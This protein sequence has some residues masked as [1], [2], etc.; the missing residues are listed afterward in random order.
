[1]QGTL[2]PVR[3]SFYVI[4]NLPFKLDFKDDQISVVSSNLKHS[5]FKI[6]AYTSLHWGVRRKA[7][8]NAGRRQ[9][10]LKSQ[11][12]EKWGVYA[13]ALNNVLPAKCVLKFWCFLSGSS[14][15][16]YRPC[17]SVLLGEVQLGEVQH[18][19]AH[20]CKKLHTF[21]TVRFGAECTGWCSLP[22]NSSTSFP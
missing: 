4:Y 9:A 6:L 11:R 20:Y 13:W 17:S 5:E 16:L 18:S 2:K 21:C 12:W 15:K 10:W 14:R 19:V 22:L 3:W 8:Q 1:M 7:F